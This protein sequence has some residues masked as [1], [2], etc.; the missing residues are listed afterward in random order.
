VSKIGGTIIH[1]LS[2]AKTATHVVAKDLKRTI[3]LMIGLCCTDKVVSLDWLRASAESETPLPC[4]SYLV[5][6]R[7][8]SNKITKNLQKGK[9][10]EQFRFYFCDSITKPPPKECRL[11]VEAAG[12]TMLTDRLLSKDVPM[13]NLFLIRKGNSF[14]KKEKALCISCIDAGATVWTLEE[15]L[16]TLMTQSRP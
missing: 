9:V 6:D 2:E 7:K 8:L 3:K 10:L 5:I 1:D 14:S 13:K 16:S 4:N 11:L 12:G 15:L